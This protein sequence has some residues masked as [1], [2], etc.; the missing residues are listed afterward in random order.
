MLVSAPVPY[1]CPR[2]PTQ[3]CAVDFS[4]KSHTIALMKILL[5]N[6]DGLFAPGLAAL[7]EALLGL[8][9]LDVIAPEEVQSGEGHSLTIREALLCS[10]R[11]VNSNLTGWAVRGRPADC[12]KLAIRELLDERPDLVISGLNAGANVGI[13]VIYS[14]TVAAA[15]E[16]A[17][18][19]IP[20]VAFSL[21][22]A[23]DQN[24]EQI[25]QSM[26]RASAL[27]RQ[28]LHQALDDGL[29]KGVVLN[30][31][32]PAHAKPKGIRF[33]KQSTVGIDDHYTCRQNAQGQLC[34]TMS[35]DFAFSHRTPD[36]D[37]SALAE[38]FVTVTPLHFDL[39]NQEQLHILS[40]N[41]WRI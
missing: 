3:I 18:F 37:V 10:K 31:N 34:Y 41:C 39:T 29:V 32:I 38:G 14:G 40:D 12:V 4:Q 17:F 2:K 8:G 25:H 23:P 33:A 15:V 36:T 22:I 26:K 35:L 7:H 27:A 9:T 28:I 6:D 13:N 20:A 21:E 24:E 16:A 19:R 5:T 1:P 11:R 30:V